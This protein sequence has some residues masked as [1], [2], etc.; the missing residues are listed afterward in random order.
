[1]IISSKNVTSERSKTRIWRARDG[2]LLNSR[3]VRSVAE[4]ALVYVIF[5]DTRGWQDPRAD[6]ILLINEDTDPFWQMTLFDINF[7]EMT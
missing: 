2:Y 7:Q 4:I 6:T 5:Q 3:I 1:M